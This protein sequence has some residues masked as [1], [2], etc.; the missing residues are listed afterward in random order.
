M[1]DQSRVERNRQFAQEAFV[2]KTRNLE[3]TE[4]A[5]IYRGGG[6]TVPI[7]RLLASGQYSW[8]NEMKGY[9]AMIPDW[10]LT[11][12]ALFPSEEGVA[13]WAVYEG[14]AAD[15]ARA[16]SLGLAGKRMR[17][18]DADIWFLDDDLKIWKHVQEIPRIEPV[19]ALCI[20]AEAAA[21]INSGASAEA[22]LQAVR[23]FEK[24]GRFVDPDTP[25]VAVAPT[26]AWLVD[27]KS[28]PMPLG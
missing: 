21:G 5:I 19:I 20:G 4:D 16:R 2:D 6:S 14:T 1:V 7:G 22:Y 24:T 12:Y 26:A 23:D 3:W 28:V 18:E 15:N 25:A 9:L 11:E 13:I 10:H 8:E 17:V 27:G